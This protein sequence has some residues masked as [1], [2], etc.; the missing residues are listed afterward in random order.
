[1]SQAQEPF[2]SSAERHLRLLGRILRSSV[3]RRYQSAFEETTGLALHLL[4][5]DGGLL[6]DHD[7][8]HRNTFCELLHSYN[9]AC[10]ECC[11][12]W[13][14]MSLF[15][16][17]DQR[18]FTCF[19]GLC[20][21][22]VP[23][24]VGS[25]TIGLLIAGE[26]AMGPPSQAK[27]DCI[28]ARLRQDGHVI[29][30]S[31]LQ[32]AYFSTPAF[33]RKH[34]ESVLNLLEVF[35]GHLSL[36]AYQIELLDGGSTDPAIRRARKYIHA[37]LGEPLVLKDVARRA[38]LSTCYFSTKFKQSTGMPFTEYVA[39]ARVEKA[40][41][42]LA[43]PGI[44]VSEIAFAVGFQ[45]LTQFNRSFKSITGCSPTRFRD[46]FARAMAATIQEAPDHP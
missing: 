22:C 30:K 1:M 29:E 21:S 39:Q 4:S 12:M 45:S 24:R 36:V 43:A 41:K 18:H 37:H 23:I 38:D 15:G 33:T 25:K 5:T 19:A 28:V 10:D 26:V 7:A 2:Q 17:G 14:R 16:D 27:F 46:G 3:F 6:V 13:R 34:Y 11:K 40:K 9:T 35:A 44:R 20:E 8:R 31:R 42:L 32:R